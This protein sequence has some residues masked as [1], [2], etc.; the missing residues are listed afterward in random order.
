M[1]RCVQTFGLYCIYIYIYSMVKALTEVGV[2]YIPGRGLRQTFPAAP[3]YTLGPAKFIRLPP[4]PA[5]P[6][7]HQVVISAQLSP[8][9]HPS[10]QDMQP[11][12]RRHNYKVGP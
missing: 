2:E 6:T 11:K 1:R 4:L 3:Y 12:V 5:N 7:H 9:F 10:V 8:S